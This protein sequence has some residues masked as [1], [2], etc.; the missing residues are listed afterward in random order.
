MANYN[1][2]GGRRSDDY[3]RPNRKNSD[4]FRYSDDRKP[5]FNDDRKPR[6]DGDRKPSRIRETRRSAL[7]TSIA[8][9]A[10][11]FIGG[12]LAVKIVAKTTYIVYHKYIR[13]GKKF[14]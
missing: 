9:T 4:G 10:L 2:R 7:H 5:R 12:L 13:S 14:A 1:D 11:K 3:K 8:N 6:F